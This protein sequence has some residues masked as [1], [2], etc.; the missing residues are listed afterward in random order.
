M[1]VFFEKD[2]NLK[3]LKKLNDVIGDLITNDAFD[4]ER[5]E[6]ICIITQ[7]IIS[8]PKS[9]DESCQYNIDDIGEVFISFIVYL[10]E[11]AEKNVVDNLVS[12][13]FRFLVEA[14]ITIEIKDVKKLYSVRKFVFENIENFSYKAKEEINYALKYMMISIFK[15]AFN[16]EEFKNIKNIS[17]LMAK[18]DELELEWENKALANK[19]KW[20]E[21]INA[22]EKKVDKLK[23][24]LDSYENAFNF[25]ALHDGFHDLF[26]SKRIERIMLI[27]SLVFVSCLIVSPLIYEFYFISKHANDIEKYRELLLF[28]LMPTFSLVVIAT[29]F[30]RVLL[31]NYKSVKSQIMQIELREHAIKSSC[32]P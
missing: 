9:W 24:S 7:S 28:S 4:K 14:L 16:S 2:E 26:K 11:N 32:A 30:F 22:K 21:E 20:D 8:N 12:F 19:E 23:E 15:K 5:N 1:I 18:K 27:V 25:V 29:Y 13:L 31:S 10:D 3:N 6:N 17:S